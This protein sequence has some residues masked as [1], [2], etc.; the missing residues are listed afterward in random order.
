[1]VSLDKQGM[2]VFTHAFVLQDRIV[3][4]IGQVYAHTHN[5]QNDPNRR[6]PEFPFLELTIEILL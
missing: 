2:C 3:T 5:D 6:L 1:M 4:T